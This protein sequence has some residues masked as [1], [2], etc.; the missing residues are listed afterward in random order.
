MDCHGHLGELLKFLRVFC[1]GSKQCEMVEDFLKKI[2]RVILNLIEV[3]N[4][5]CLFFF[6]TLVAFFDC[7]QL[8]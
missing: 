5:S 2:F 7:I 1:F 8:P 6:L 4:D 3:F